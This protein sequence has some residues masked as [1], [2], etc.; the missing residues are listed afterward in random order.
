MGNFDGLPSPETI[1]HGATT[2]QAQRSQ[3]V[4]E[5]EPLFFEMASKLRGLE[6][7]SVFELTKEKP[8]KSHWFFGIGDPTPAVTQRAWELGYR[9]P[10]SD[11][12]C[13]TY[14]L[15]DG[16]VYPDLESGIR[17]LLAVELYLWKKLGDAD[18]PAL[19]AHARRLVIERLKQKYINQWCL[20]R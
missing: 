20:G 19:V 17:A 14:L 3:F 9:E 6:P 16:S 1:Q 5:L 4:K 2:A 7:S 12:P 10:E 18:D 13:M 11:Y 15:P 8:G